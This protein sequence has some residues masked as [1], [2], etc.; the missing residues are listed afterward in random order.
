MAT[1]TTLEKDLSPEVRF[2]DMRKHFCEIAVYCAP[3]S[4]YD[5]GKRGKMWDTSEFGRVKIDHWIWRYPRDWL[6]GHGKIRS[7]ERPRI[8]EGGASFFD[9]TTQTA[10]AYREKEGES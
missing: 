6:R 7:H 9:D 5:H 1:T 8:P 10:Q 4:Y 2:H 3:N